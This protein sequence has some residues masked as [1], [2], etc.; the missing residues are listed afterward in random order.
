MRS[1]KFKRMFATIMVIA[2][3]TVL[4]AC[5]GNDNNAATSSQPA[6]QS[7]EPTGSAT[8]TESVKVKMLGHTTWFVQGM[9][10]VIPEAKKNGFELIIEKVPEGD[11][12][13][14]LMKTRFATNDKPDILFYQSG[15][16][17]KF[18]FGNPADVFVAQDD[19]PWMANFDKVAW[20]NQMDT[21]DDGHWYGAPYGGTDMG[22]VLYN[23][24]MFDE[25]KLQVPTNMDEF[26]AVAEAIKAAGKTPIYFSGQDAWTV[27][28]PVLLSNATQA[29]AETIPLINEN[30]A[31]MTDLTDR[32]VGMQFIQ[33]AVS[34]GYANKDILSST[35]DNAQKALSSGE[36]GMYHMA[37]WVMNEIVSKYPEGVE[38][39]GSFIMPYKGNGQD[40]A[41]IWSPKSLYVVKGDNQDNAQK[42]VNWFEQPEVQDIFFAK[43]GGIPTIK[44]VTQTSLTP[45]EL[46]AKKFLDEGKAMGNSPYPFLYNGDG[47]LPTYVQE[48]F[49]K[50]GKNPDQVLEAL[51]KDLEIDAKAKGDANYK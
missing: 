42:F 48:L 6:S 29:V 15:L 21:I 17:A 20:K 49:V 43:Q 14:N 50:N 16:G 7:N 32:K 2:L 40:L 12:G 37:T 41:A 35:Y 51:Q 4:T 25:L 47:N 11:D 39:I 19:Q 45:A 5:G 31:K 44:G 27:Q 34:K 30:K 38:N 8:P 24:K 18:G 1:K 22:V 13:A 3:I 33:D 28:L 23:K 36:A 10:A 26:W 46:D 9:E